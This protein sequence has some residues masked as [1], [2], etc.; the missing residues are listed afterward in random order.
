MITREPP[1]AGAPPRPPPRGSLQEAFLRP[2]KATT[3]VLVVVSL[4]SFAGFQSEDLLRALAKDNDAIRAGE[5]WR[6]LTAGLV[7][8]GL[9]HLFMNGFV[10][11]NVGGIVERLLGPARMLLVLWGSVAAGS[12]ASFATNP[13]PSVGISGGVFGLVG[14]LLAVGVRY[15]RR[16]PPP[17]RGM[18]VRGPLEAIILNLALGLSLPFIDNAAHLGGLAGGFAL[19]LVLGPRPA[20]VAALG[21]PKTPTWTRSPGRAESPGG[22][23]DEPTRP[24]PWRE[25]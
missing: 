13:G 12:L 10:L 8:A 20:L 16:L 23:G 7:H 18:L 2:A 22:P 4:V 9:F 19:A 14:A 6:L 1:D 17:L 25:G 3:A 24:P 11:N 5:V 21:G 15:R